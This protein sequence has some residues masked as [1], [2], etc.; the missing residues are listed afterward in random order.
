MKPTDTP[1]RDLTEGDLDA[2]L[3]AHF[4]APRRYLVTQGTDMDH[5]QRDWLRKARSVPPLPPAEPTPPAGP[6]VT[7]CRPVPL[8]TRWARL[9]WAWINNRKT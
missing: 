8:L 7:P 4:A 2:R 6:T 5:D 9:L 1:V 3:D